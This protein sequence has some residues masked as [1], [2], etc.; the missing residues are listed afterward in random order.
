[1]HRARCAITRAGEITWGEVR[2]DASDYMEFRLV[3]EGSLKSGQSSGKVEEKHAVRKAIHK[4]LKRLWEIVPD[5]KMR[6]T[7]HSLL[8]VT[9][10]RRNPTT[11]TTAAATFRDSLWEKLGNKFDK[12]SGF[13]FVPLVGNNLQLTCGLDILILQR[14]K[15][16]PIGKTGDIDNRLKTLFDALQVPVNCEEL[17]PGVVKAADEDPYFFCLT[18]DDC[19]I[20]DVRIAVDKWLAPFTPPAGPGAS[21]PENFVH[22]VMTVKVRPS[23]FS[24]ENLAFVT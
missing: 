13:K 16:T 15:A 9:P 1:M 18:E 22:L 19:L 12:C 14:D 5:L 21:H 24:F 17:P 2:E 3:Y 8:S 23:I 6:S 20:T 7:E 4:Q 11:I 10:A